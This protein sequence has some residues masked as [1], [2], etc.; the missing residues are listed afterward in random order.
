MSAQP[1][2]FGPIDLRPIQVDMQRLIDLLDV[3]GR[4]RGF[5]LSTAI[6]PVVDVGQILELAGGKLGALA[7]LASP[8]EVPF[9]HAPQAGT[10][11]LP[12]YARGFS[13]MSS[14]G[15]SD[16]ANVTDSLS[17]LGP[18]QNAAGF[19]F[20]RA[21]VR[22]AA[23]AAQVSFSAANQEVLVEVIGGTAAATTIHSVFPT[24]HMTA[25]FAIPPASPLV[26]AFVQFNPPQR[27]IPN[28]GLPHTSGDW[29]GGPQGFLR[30]R[31]SVR[32]AAVVTTVVQVLAQI[33]PAI[34]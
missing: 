34:D 17:E 5:D 6:V 21:L 7:P 25:P 26:T 18:L 12:F 19:P 1:P 4:T 23:I 31:R 27:V 10:P 22:V 33:S 20:E 28:G 24:F 13:W 2:F 32:T 3:K 14:V 11:E 15:F 16:A 9:P 8:F 29:G 30:L